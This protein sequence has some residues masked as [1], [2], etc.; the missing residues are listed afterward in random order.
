MPLENLD[1]LRPVAGN[2]QIAG[3]V[4]FNPGK[5]EDAKTSK[6]KG[7]LV[8]IPTDKNK[9]N[10]L[11]TWEHGDIELELDFMMAKGSNAGLYLQGRY[12]IQLFDSWGVKNPK[13][14]DCGGIYERW[15]ESR[16][17]GQKGY[18]GHPPRINVSKAPGLWQHYRI[19]F[20]APRFDNSG[21][22]TANARFVKVM[23]NGVVIHENVELSGPT[24]SA[25]FN[26][27][28]AQGPL[29]IQ[30]DHG[31]VAVRNIR[32]KKFD[33]APVALQNV[34]YAYYEGKFETLPDLSKL[35]P[36]QSGPLE[37]ITWEAGKAPNDFAFRFT[38]NLQVKEAGEYRFELVATGGY[39]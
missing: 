31:K 25:A 14:S 28:K 15:D 34:Q 11:T 5:Y 2:W 21:K 13:A 6:G 32:Y 10:I 7:I 9:D 20:Q 29:M 3:E 17:E 33:K 19:I 37:S 4:Y 27:E 12:E 18:E 39:W 22:K 36:V 30:G 16:P 23:H 35:K 26:D 1:G 38:G 8:N 24:R